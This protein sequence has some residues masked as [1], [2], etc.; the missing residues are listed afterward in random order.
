MTIRQAWSRFKSLFN[1]TKWPFFLLFA[2]YCAVGERSGNLYSLLC[3]ML[4]CAVVFVFLFSK[5]L[6]VEAHSR[7]SGGFAG[8]F[9]KFGLMLFVRPIIL[10]WPVILLAFVLIAGL[11]LIFVTTASDTLAR[12]AA[13]RVFYILARWLGLFMAL[14]IARRKSQLPMRK[15]R[16][17]IAAGAIALVMAISAIAEIVFVWAGDQ[18]IFLI[19]PIRRLVGE[20]DA[21]SI[22]QRISFFEYYLFLVLYV[23]NCEDYSKKRRRRREQREQQE[24]QEAQG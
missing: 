6:P 7:E 1:D 9:V 18:D 16:R 2:V 23:S 3:N 4:F 22:A 10:I 21:D 8:Y 15:E 14:E 11:I 17:R 19:G 13:F 20:S 12:Q 5:V 24:P